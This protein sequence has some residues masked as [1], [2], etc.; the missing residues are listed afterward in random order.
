LILLDSNSLVYAT[1]RQ[2]DPKIA[3]LGVRLRHYL[4]QLSERETPVAIPSL[5]LYEYLCGY[6]VEDH[7][8]M[9]SA[10]ETNYIILDVGVAAASKAAEL[11]R[12]RPADTGPK[13]R[14]KLDTLIAATAVVE[15]VSEIVS[16]D[17]DYTALTLGQIATKKPSQLPKPPRDLFE[18]TPDEQ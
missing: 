6:P 7:P 4:A 12:N 10:L 5:L 11:F 13:Q 14:A 16:E 1:E 17:R 18:D 9:V 3:E 15:G 2:S 8:Q